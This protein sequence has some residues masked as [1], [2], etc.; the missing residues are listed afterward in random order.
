MQE[1]K[2]RYH[3][4]G[5]GGVGMSAIAQILHAKGAVVSGSDRQESNITRRLRDSGMKVTIG[6]SA[7]NINGADIVVYTA[8]IAKNN[9]EMMEAQRRGLPLVERPVM[10]GK[11][12]EPYQH[13]VAITGTHGKTTTTS[14]VS[15]ILSCAG[16]DATV[17]I[18]GDVKSLGSNVR[19]GEGG[20]I[21]A[22]ACEAYGSFLHLY[23]S[24]ATV[25][26]IDVDHLDYYGNVE[27]I[28]EGFRKFISQ[29][30]A[31]GCVVAN[32]DD[33][34]TRRVVDNC[35]RRV[36]WF[37]LSDAAQMRAEAVNI[38]TPEPTYTLV[39]NGNAVGDICLSVPGMQN[40][41]DSLAAAAVAYELD[42]DFEVIKQGL[43]GF[44]GVGRRFDIL[45]NNGKVM[46][47]DDY[48]HHPTE[49]KATLEAVRA[50]YDKHVIAV[51]QPH[52]Y[53]RTQQLMD[54][55]VKALTLADEVIIAPIYA[56]R[57]LPIEGVTAETIAVKMKK[58]GFV[59]VRYSPDKAAI[60]RELAGRV[61]EGDMVIVIGAGD[62]RATG[63]ELASILSGETNGK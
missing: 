22:E 60:A 52:L 32:V 28:E 19:L 2:L 47:V 14:M 42:I 38:S 31:D 13:R 46:V 39:R 16:A 59:N 36:V 1:E 43:R 12:M 23:P 11:L 10:L 9:P 50:A 62:I 33:V 21:V 45:Y 29:I 15:T 56:A 54:E 40:V 7:E 27:H 35:S 20:V 61:T 58:N 41:V 34:R 3:F 49:I 18:G 63:E 25:L 4:I 57:E 6:H 26:N 44:K 30:D 37:G 48:A 17:L 8:A 24:I 55:F 5:I 51:F 53:S